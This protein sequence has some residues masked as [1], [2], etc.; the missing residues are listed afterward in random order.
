MVQNL[1]RRKRWRGRRLN[2][3]GAGI[4]EE[5]EHKPTVQFFFYFRNLSSSQLVSKQN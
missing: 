2:D 3:K 1:Q 4:G 5:K